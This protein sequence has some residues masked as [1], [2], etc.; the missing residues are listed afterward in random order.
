VLEAWFRFSP[1]LALL[2]L[3]YESDPNSFLFD[4][5]G[6]VDDLNLSNALRNAL[7]SGLQ[8]SAAPAGLV[9]VALFVQRSAQASSA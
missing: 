8:W 5:D 7:D 3:T 1:R 4:I 6:A 2:R 9:D